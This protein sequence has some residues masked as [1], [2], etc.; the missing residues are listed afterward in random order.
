MLCQRGIRL[1]EPTES[2]VVSRRRCG[3]RGDRHVQSG[4]GPQLVSERALTSNSERGM[5]KHAHVALSRASNAL[6]RHGD[7]DRCVEWIGHAA[8]RIRAAG[9]V[10]RNE[11]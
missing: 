2:P 6:M 11:L 3:D 8:R 10:E 7:P 5:H 9:M 1:F 4:I